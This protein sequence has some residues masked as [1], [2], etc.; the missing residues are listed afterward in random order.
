MTRV[1]LTMTAK[2]K[3]PKILNPGD[4]IGL[5]T[6][7]KYCYTLKKRSYWLCKCECGN[8]IILNRRLILE[9]KNVDCGC[10][11]R[12]NRGISINRSQKEKNEFRW[13]CIKNLSHWEGKCLIWEGYMQ[14]GTTPGMSTPEGRTTVRKWIWEFFKGKSKKKFKTVTCGNLKCINIEHIKESDNGS[15]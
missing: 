4:K 14:K 13:N 8:E 1:T 6:I 11:A 7:L 5:L 12:I 2:G 10:V 3:S 15:Y 9:R